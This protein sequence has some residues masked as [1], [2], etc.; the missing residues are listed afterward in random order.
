MVLEVECDSEFTH[1][2]MTQYHVIMMWTGSKVNMEIPLNGLIFEEFHKNESCFTLFGF[3]KVS[4][5]RNPDGGGV[6]LHPLFT[7]EFF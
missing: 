6:I 5:F 3:L 1:D 4:S 7:N 2:I